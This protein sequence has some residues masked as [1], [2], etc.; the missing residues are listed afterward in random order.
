MSKHP[1]RSPNMKCGLATMVFVVCCAAAASAARAPLAPGL[2]LE[3]MERRFQKQLAALVSYEGQ[4]RYSVEHRLLS[5]PATWLVQES[6]AAP[7]EKQFTILEQH[8]SA[9]VQNRVFAPLL[10]VERQTARE[11]VRPLVDISRQNYDFEFLRYDEKVDA[12][13]FKVS[14]R[15]SSK[16]LLRG[17]VWVDAEDFGIQ[18]IEGEPEHKHSLLI[19]SVHFIHEFARFGEFW[20]PVRHRS[21]TELHLFGQ[22]TL[23]IDY[24]NYRWQAAPKGGRL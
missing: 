6:Y 19:R 4:R 3:N 9:L 14:P 15:G 7:G 12:Y 1:E 16:Y 24:Y 10:D 2:V 5:E 23:E 8:G 13:L 22:A 18:R 20:L 17:S 21:V 11:T